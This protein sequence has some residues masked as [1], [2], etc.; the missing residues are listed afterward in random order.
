MTFLLSTFFPTVISRF[1][2][3][4]F[5]PETFRKAAEFYV[6]FSRKT[7]AVFADGSMFSE[8]AR[9]PS[10]KKGFFFCFLLV[11]EFWIRLKGVKSLISLN[12]FFFISKHFNF[13][14]STSCGKVE[15]SAL[16]QKQRMNWLEF[17]LHLHHLHHHHHNF[18]LKALRKLFSGNFPWYVWV[19][20]SNPES[21]C[22]IW[23]G[24]KIPPEIENLSLNR[25]LKVFPVFSESGKI[26]KFLTSIP[27]RIGYFS[28]YPAAV[29]F[30][31]REGKFSIPSHESGRKIGKINYRSL[32]LIELRVGVLAVFAVS[33]Y[34][35]VMEG[36]INKTKILKQ[37]Y[38][39]GR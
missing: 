28:S 21:V 8:I 13:I 37:F 5:S 39:N 6:A 25:S 12:F 4:P 9:I 36:E 29:S 15:L 10:L 35:V 38:A 7:Q 33:G 3:L 11:L 32:L 26:H 18:V 19:L 14:F 27:S 23:D 34:L 16:Y 1:A 31:F 24:R 17:L 2:I 30:S 20:P 22:G